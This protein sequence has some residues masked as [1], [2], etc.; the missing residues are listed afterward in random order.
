MTTISVLKMTEAASSVASSPHVTPCCDISRMYRSQSST[1]TLSRSLK[2]SPTEPSSI[3]RPPFSLSHCTVF[4]RIEMADQPLM[5]SCS[6]WSVSAW[7][8]QLL[9]PGTSLIL[10]PRK[11]RWRER[12]ERASCGPCAIRS[13]WLLISADVCRTRGTSRNPLPPSPQLPRPGVGG[14]AGA[15]AGAACMPG[16]SGGSIGPAGGGAVGGR[17]SAAAAAALADEEEE[18]EE[19]GRGGAT[20]GGGEGSPFGSC[21][22]GRAMV[23]YIVLAKVVW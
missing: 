10:K 8:W 22:T 11:P 13:L 7:N 6:S 14:A 18:E 16:G 20:A 9:S 23:G 1:P 5:P 17:T 19:G 12:R 15:A 2:D 3:A 21:R 4:F